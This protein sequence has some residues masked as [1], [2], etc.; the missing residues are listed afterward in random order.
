MT[1]LAQI[2]LRAADV[3]R[4]NGHYQGDYF[5]DSRNREM[6]VPCHLRPMSII[7]ALRCAA[8]GDPRQYSLLADEALMDLADRLTVD[9]EGSEYG[10]IFSLESHIEDWGDAEGRTDAEVIAALED[11]ARQNA[12]A[13]AVA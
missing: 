9:G 6:D 11:A 1:D 13:K 8:T 10:D 5:P 12:A 7:A 4:T 3:I 2:Y